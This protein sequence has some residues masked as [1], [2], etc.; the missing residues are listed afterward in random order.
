MFRNAAEITYFKSDSSSI[1][2]GKFGEHEFMAIKKNYGPIIFRIF[3]FFF[4]L[5]ALY[6]TVGFFFPYMVIPSHHWRHGV[7]VLVNLVGI[8]LILLRPPWAIL[9]FFIMMLQGV[10]SHTRRA[11]KWWLTDQRIDWIS[12]GVIIVLPLVIFF[13]Y[14]DIREKILTKRKFYGNKI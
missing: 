13:L 14:K 2:T 4:S 8:W 6:H 11:L 10:N 5:A 3:A 1:G 7:F 12:I 9:P